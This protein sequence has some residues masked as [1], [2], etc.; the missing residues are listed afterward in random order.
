MKNNERKDLVPIM[1]LQNEVHPKKLKN[2]CFQNYRKAG[3]ICK[4]SGA[5]T[6]IEHVQSS[7]ETK[8]RQILEQITLKD[9]HK[10]KKEITL[11]S[12]TCEHF[13][14]FSFPKRRI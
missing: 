11:I 7:P 13:L 12:C 5:E 3:K 2:V 10:L 1:Q 6:E 8:T 9:V 14:R 4:K